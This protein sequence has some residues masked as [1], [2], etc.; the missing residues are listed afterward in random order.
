MIEDDRALLRA[1]FDAAVDAALPEKLIARHLPNPPKGKTIV[2]GAGKAS[3]AM[4]RAF[5]DAWTGPCEGLVVTRYDHAVPCQQIEIVE[6]SHPVPD[7]AGLDAARRILSMAEQAG[8]DDLVIALISG[9]GSSLLTLPAE[10]IE[11]ADKQ[12]LN[13]ALLSCGA[14][15]D[16]MNAVRKH[17]S[18]IKGGRLA[19]A[20]FPAAL[21]TLAISDVP[22]DDPAVIASGPTVAD[23]S[24]FAD[25]RAILARRGVTPAPTITRHLDAAIDETPKSGDPRLAK[26]AFQ[27][28]ATPQLSLDAAA[29]IARAAGMNPIMLGDALE[30][31]ARDL[32][33]EMAKRALNCSGPAVLLSGGETTV[34]LP[35]GEAPKG[36]GGR[37]VEFL[38]GLASAL[39]G[40][41][42]ISAIACDT[43]GVDGMEDVA[44]AIIDPTTLARC[45][46]AGIS[47]ETA[48]RE[49][50]GHG[51][52]KA[53]GDQ[54]ITGPTLTNVNDFRAIIVN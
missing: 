27:M 26:C 19:A 23:A 9:G 1:L 43:D 47:I 54:V 32:G 46:A 31:E 8:P 14:P 30:G 48:M 18:A 22:G 34:T 38:L 13:S 37:N 16:E 53:L 52:F 40:A 11:F 49:H 36:R 10:G 21:L 42:N 35:Q 33:A 5:E 25:A 20:A 7:Q 28:I 17:V 12:A 29:D 39:N 15:I 41:A 6:A 24:T 50:D 2:I 44:G 3:A 45:T 4:A 51:F